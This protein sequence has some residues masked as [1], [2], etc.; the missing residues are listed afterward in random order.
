MEKQQ[1]VNKE[2]ERLEIEEIKKRIKTFKSQQLRSKSRERS[3]SRSGSKTKE[4][5]L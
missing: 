5:K 3:K 1:E 4:V 2:R